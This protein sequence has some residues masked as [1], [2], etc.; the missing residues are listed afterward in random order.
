MNQDLSIY[1]IA[2]EAGVSPATVSRVMTQS[3]N[4]S[5]EKRMRVQAV[6]NK[7]DYRPNA[8]AKG[9]TNSKTKIIGMLTANFENPYYAKLLTLCEK[10]IDAY[11]YTP[12]ICG[13]MGQYDLE[14]KHLQDMFDLRLDAIVMMGGKSDDLVTCPEF[15]DL[16]NRISNKVPIITTGKVD[17]ARCYQV[18]LDEMSGIDLAMEH[19]I[20][21]GHSRI[22]LIG[23]KS[24]IKSTFDKVSRYKSIL[25]MY[26]IDYR[27]NFVVET[28]YD[29]SSGYESMQQMLEYNEGSKRPTAVIA[30]N[31]FCAVGMLHAIRDASLKVPED[32][33]VVS[34][35]NTYLSESVI[36]NLTSVGYDYETFGKTI[37]DTAM[38]LI[39]GEMV[40]TMQQIATK[41]FIR[42]STIE[43]LK[44]QTK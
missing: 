27:Q 19:L 22:A 20:S 28:G 31:E 3:A 1:T 21:L 12:M 5:E 25:R 11:G 41:L 7:Y 32:I 4:V 16:V 29:I 34:F 24:N 18:C 35:D 6:I 39:D 10:D 9:L 36:P 38:K 2:K 23:G 17:G 30:I 26:G 13:T 15:A 44:K 43:I 14:V 37:V 8:M 40:P 42:E 33:A